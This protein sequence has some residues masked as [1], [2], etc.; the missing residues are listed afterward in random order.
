MSAKR[1]SSN[2]PSRI[3]T[4]LNMTP[5]LLLAGSR[6]RDLGGLEF[7]NGVWNEDKNIF[8]QHT[9]YISIKYITIYISH[10]IFFG[11]IFQYG[12]L[13]IF[14][15]WTKAARKF[16]TAWNR[17]F[18]SLGRTKEIS[19]FWNKFT[20]LHVQRN[21]SLLLK[22]KLYFQHFYNGPC[23]SSSP[24]ELSSNLFFHSLIL[25]NQK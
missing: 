8:W 25:I 11:K 12:N 14:C 10:K 16:S 15:W 23:H 5:Y 1:I 4:S 3:F 24:L 19:E 9:L 17:K 21:H 18:C 22:S 2:L 20:I 6:L 13:S 7:N